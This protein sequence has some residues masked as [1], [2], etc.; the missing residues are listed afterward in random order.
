MEADSDNFVRLE[1]VM[2]G[3]GLLL[4]EVNTIVLLPMGRVGV[5]GYPVTIRRR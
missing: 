1:L 4:L 2:P 3:W 5:Y